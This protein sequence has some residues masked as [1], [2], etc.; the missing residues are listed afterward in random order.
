MTVFNNPSVVSGDTPDPMACAGGVQA[1][2]SIAGESVKTSRVRPLAVGEG[3]AQLVVPPSKR[4]QFGMTL[5]TEAWCYDD[6]GDEIGHVEVARPLRYGHIPGVLVLSPLAA[7]P[8]FGPEAG[9]VAPTAQRGVA[10]CV[11]SDLY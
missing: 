2:L 9:C 1:S 5:V 7:K 10:L 8:T 3:T 4:L 6:A 11:L